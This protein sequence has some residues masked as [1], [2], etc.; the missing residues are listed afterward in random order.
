ML[1][2]L[3]EFLIRGQFYKTSQIHNGYT[4]ADVLHDAQIVR[5]KKIGEVHLLLELGEQVDNLGLDGDI[6]G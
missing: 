2:V 4:V 1:G 5:N 3:I 6:Q